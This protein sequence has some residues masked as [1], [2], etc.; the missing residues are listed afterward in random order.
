MPFYPT[1]MSKNYINEYY[2]S[3]IKILNSIIRILKFKLSKKEY[4]EFEKLYNSDYI[5]IPDKDFQAILNE[6]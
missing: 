3:K 4:K 2:V 6:K 1:P 5:D